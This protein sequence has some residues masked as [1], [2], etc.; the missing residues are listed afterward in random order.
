[1]KT[2]LQTT[3]GFSG[4]RKRKFCFGVLLYACLSV[5]PVYAAKRLSGFGQGGIGLLEQS[6]RTVGFKQFENNLPLTTKQDKR[7]HGFGTKSISMICEKHQ[8]H[9]T[10][11]VMKDIFEVR[12]VF[13]MV[14][15]EAKKV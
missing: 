3:D 15:G 13:P 12:I 5:R 8:G 10:M 6:R 4:R 2:I 14:D 1:M 7:Y 11:N 9:C